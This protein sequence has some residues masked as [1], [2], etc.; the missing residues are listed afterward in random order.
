VF[1]WVAY[2]CTLVVG[3]LIGSLG[4]RLM[5]RPYQ[6]T[7][8][9]VFLNPNLDPRGAGWNT[10][11][12]ITAV[13]SG[14]LSGK[15]FLQ[16]TQTHFQYLPQQ[17]TDFIFSIIAEEWGFVGSFVVFALFMAVFVRGLFIIAYARDA[18]GAYLAGGILA[19]LFFHFMVNIG[20]AIGV[21]PITGIPLFFL[22]Y[23]G[24]PLI[25]GML[26]VGLLLSIYNRKY[27]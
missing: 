4:A 21:L 8:L 25:A 24:S 20:M 14:G 6:V 15:G 23:G 13:G 10:I 27:R 1:Y 12:S 22:S 2:G 19:L 11:Q 16:G 17:S 9:L 7:R 18:F 3:S 26:G 5:L